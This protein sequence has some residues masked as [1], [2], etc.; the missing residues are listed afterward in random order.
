MENV[1]VGQGSAT[2]QSQ[3]MSHDNGWH[4][5]ASHLDFPPGF[6][7]WSTL[8]KEKILVKDDPSWGIVC[9]S[10]LQLLKHQNCIL[11]PADVPVRSVKQRGHPKLVGWSRMWMWAI[12]GPPDTP[13]LPKAPSPWLASF[14][15]E[16][17]LSSSPPLRCPALFLASVYIK[18]R[19]RW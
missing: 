11:T 15:S 19:S 18:G 7:G 17:V 4:F 2:Q 6:A 3:R 10:P 14:L 8:K 5:Y 13:A 9:P 16:F 1:R 12:V